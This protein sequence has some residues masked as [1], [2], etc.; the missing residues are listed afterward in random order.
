[1]GQPPGESTELVK[2][3]GDGS[4]E[5]LVPKQEQIGQGCQESQFTGDAPFQIVAVDPKLA[6][7]GQQ[8][9]F[10]GQSPVKA[11]VVNAAE[12]EIA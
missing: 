2:R 10:G 1:M 5:P 6:K 11:I 12:L 8:S 9:Q 3:R 7:V 4:V